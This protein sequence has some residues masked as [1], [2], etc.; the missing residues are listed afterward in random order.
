MSSASIAQVCKWP[1]AAPLLLGGIYDLLSA[2]DTARAGRERRQQSR[3]MQALEGGLR[4]LSILT[5]WMIDKEEGDD[6]TD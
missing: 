6:D 1:Q 2:I 4:V 5:I 3:S